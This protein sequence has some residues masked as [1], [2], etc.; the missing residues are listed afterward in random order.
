MKFQADQA[1]MHPEIMASMNFNNRIKVEYET[2]SRK[3][4]VVAYN[5]NSN[6]K[7]NSLLRPFY[8]RTPG[9]VRPAKLDHTSW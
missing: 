1:M 4:L 2:G 9:V 5:G 7:I 8:A 6:H 3:H